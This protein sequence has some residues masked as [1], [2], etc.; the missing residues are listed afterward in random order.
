MPFTS[1]IK[2]TFYD[3][4]TNEVVKEYCQWFIPWNLLKPAVRLTRSLEGKAL[5]DL[6]EE[7]IDSIASLVVEVFCHQFSL[8][9][10]RKNYASLEEMWVVVQ[11]IGTRSGGL[12]PNPPP[13]GE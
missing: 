10:I 7:E 11:D 5:T 12:M 8:D 6:S 3:P 9:D 1:P 13:K 4:A 2:F